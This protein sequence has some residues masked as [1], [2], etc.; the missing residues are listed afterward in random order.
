MEATVRVAS[1][2]HQRA[3]E[4]VCVTRSQ[5]VELGPVSASAWLLL[6]MKPRPDSTPTPATK[7]GK[8]GLGSEVKAESRPL[9]V[10]GGSKEVQSWKASRRRS[11]LVAAC[12]GVNVLWS[13]EVPVL[14]PG[15]QD[16]GLKR[17][18]F[19]EVPGS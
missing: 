3:W 19:L 16:G 7:P 12:C 11:W 1:C 8:P 10:R 15:S 9:R 5:A 13:L 17:W 4:L 18:Y 6:W 2:A 14:K